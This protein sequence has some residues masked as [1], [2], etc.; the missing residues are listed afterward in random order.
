MDP[1]GLSTG[2]DEETNEIIS[3]SDDDDCGVYLFPTVDEKR[4]EG[5][6]FLIGFTGTPGYFADK[7]KPC[8]SPNIDIVDNSFLGKNIYDFGEFYFFGDFSFLISNTMESSSDLESILSSWREKKDGDELTSEEAEM[9]KIM[10]CI[11]MVVGFGG[12]FFTKGICLQSGAFVMADG[13]IV[14]SASIKNQ[15]CMPFVHMANYFQNPS[16]KIPNSKFHFASPL[17]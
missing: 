2:V 4:V 15:K 9:Q 13:A 17:P 12:I 6:G 16:M 10:G 1:D 7:E 5:P 14:A 8:V 11:E 3:A